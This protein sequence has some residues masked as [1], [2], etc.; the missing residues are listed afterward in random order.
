MGPGRAQEI[1]QVD[2]P[3]FADL[4]AWRQGNGLPPQADIAIISA[5]LDFPIPP[6]LTAGGRRVL[7]ITTENPD[8]GRVKEI[9][10]Q[11]GRVIVAGKGGVDG[12]LMMQRLAGL[13]YH[14][15]YSAAGPQILH[16]L[17]TGNVLDR[18]YVTLAN[19][20]L[21]GQPFAS[22]LEGPLLV[23]PVGLKIYEIC[24]DPYALDGSG[25]LFIT[26]ERA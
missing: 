5:S 4:R 1:L 17:V 14:T 25:Q 16:L 19:R 18:L 23:P 12:A 26:Y 9:E 22:I 24:L 11:A 7:V 2:D 15:I 21:G 8:P 13:G 3:R 20:L 6:V 10:A